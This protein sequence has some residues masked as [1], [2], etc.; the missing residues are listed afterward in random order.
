MSKTSAP[1]FREPRQVRPIRFLALFLLVLAVCLISGL[2]LLSSYPLLQSSMEFLIGWHPQN[3]APKLAGWLTIGL[4]VLLPTLLLVVMVRFRLRSWWWVGGGWL[5]VTPILT[6][7]A[8]DDAKLVKT[9]TI[10]QISPA[11]PGAEESYAVLMRYGRDTTAA[12]SFNPPSSIRRIVLN[13]DRN[14]ADWHAALVNNREQIESDW[15]ALAMQRAW[16]DELNSFDRIGDL[17]LPNPDADI[18]STLVFRTMSQWGWAMAGLQAI[19]GRGDDAIDTLI[20]ILQVGRKLQPSAR[21]LVRM[22]LGIT[23]EAGS[24]RTAEWI[25]DHAEVSP[26]ARARLAAALQGSEGQRGARR[27]IMAEYAMEVGYYADLPFVNLVQV[28]NVVSRTLLQVLRPFIFNQRATANLYTRQAY[29]NQELAASRTLN[30]KRPVSAYR[31]PGSI[32]PSF[33]NYMGSLIINN[34]SFNPSN[35]VASYWKNEDDRAALLARL[36]TP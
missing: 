26:A 14:P 27:L 8:V 35:A 18:P 7:L 34:I 15:A 1:F 13:P 29:I 5:I 10:E 31:P 20:P 16:W 22:M 19:D 11:F 4:I 23:I 28:Q 17:T 3:D 36:A 21:T 9:A 24:M 25:L 30:S 2:A 12:R 33:K 6:Y 32:P